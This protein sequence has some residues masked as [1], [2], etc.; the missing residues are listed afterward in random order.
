MFKDINDGV[1]N[2]DIEDVE[3][4]KEKMIYIR[5]ESLKI[6]KDIAISISNNKKEN[7]PMFK[8]F[9]EELVGDLDIVHEIS[10]YNLKYILGEK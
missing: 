9:L 7:S 8:D 6:A 3:R 1:T 4:K 5:L 10:N 2:Y